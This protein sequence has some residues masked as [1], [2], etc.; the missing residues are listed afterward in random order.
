VLNNVSLQRRLDLRLGSKN[1]FYEFYYAC[2]ALVL[3]LNLDTSY[4]LH[5]DQELRSKPRLARYSQ[6]GIT[7][8]NAR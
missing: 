7:A 2:I 5:E 8:E 1:T 4:R 3:E 6:F